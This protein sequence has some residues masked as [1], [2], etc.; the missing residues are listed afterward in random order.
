MLIDI[1]Y[2]EIKRSQSLLT[3]EYLIEFRF[4]CITWF[5]WQDDKGL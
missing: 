2:D 5:L 4:L 3:I 1:V